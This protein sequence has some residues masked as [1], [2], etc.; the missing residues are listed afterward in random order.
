MRGKYAINITVAEEEYEFV[1]LQ[2]YLKRTSMSGYLR[3]LIAREQERISNSDNQ[4]IIITK[5]PKR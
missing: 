3:R 2:A 1:R 4:K 5:L